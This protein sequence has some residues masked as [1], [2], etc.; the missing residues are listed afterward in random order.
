MATTEDTGSGSVPA[1][2]VTVD[3]AANGFIVTHNGPIGVAVRPHVFEDY[4]GMFDYLKQ[5]FGD[6]IPYDRTADKVTTEKAMR[7][8]LR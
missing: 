5:E 6:D 2:T 4:V 3:H 7:D 8:A 1:Q